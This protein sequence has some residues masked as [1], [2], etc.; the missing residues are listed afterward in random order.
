[1]LMKKCRGCGA[2]IF[3]IRMHTGRMMP[4]DTDKQVFVVDGP[5]GGQVY[6]GYRPHWAS[7]PNAADFKKKTTERGEHAVI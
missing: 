1:M 5:V 4:C 2:T 3:W 6:K 7:C